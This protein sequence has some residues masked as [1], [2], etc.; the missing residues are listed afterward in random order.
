M[1]R[2][3]EQLMALRH[4]PVTKYKSCWAKCIPT[5][6]V[7]FFF[8]CYYL[9]NGDYFIN[10]DYLLLKSDYLISNGYLINSDYLFIN[11]QEK[12]PQT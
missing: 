10:S 6:V 5:F 11:M 7:I 8:F 1:E 4:A 9:L 12:V 3:K 2:I